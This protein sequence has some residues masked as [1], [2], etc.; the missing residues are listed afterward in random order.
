MTPGLGLNDWR[1]RKKSWWSLLLNIVPHK[2][3]FVFS[4]N[5]SHCHYCH[6]SFYSDVNRCWLCRVFLGIGTKSVSQD[7]WTDT[8]IGLSTWYGLSSD[9]HRSFLHGPW[10]HQ[11]ESWKSTNVS[12]MY[13][14]QYHSAQFNAAWYFSRISVRNKNFINMFVNYLLSIVSCYT[15]IACHFVKYFRSC[16]AV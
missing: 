3:C 12:F 14:M 10:P 11:E 9:S 15:N 1:Q 16:F 2:F 6:A 13:T 8:N 4:I 7:W 5:V